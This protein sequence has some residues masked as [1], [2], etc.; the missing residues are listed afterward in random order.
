MEK[1]REWLQKELLHC[2][3]AFIIECDDSAV[4]FNGE[5]TLSTFLMSEAI[6]GDAHFCSFK[7]GAFFKKQ[8]NY[9]LNSH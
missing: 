5:P 9:N 2:T 1:G 7:P 6:G 3:Q 4:D 8:T